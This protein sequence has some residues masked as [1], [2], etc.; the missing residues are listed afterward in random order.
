MARWRRERNRAAGAAARAERGVCQRSPRRGGVRIRRSPRGIS[1][2]CPSKDGGESMICVNSQPEMTCEEAR[3]L[4]VPQ[5]VGDS[6]VTAEERE[7]F[8]G[9]LQACAACVEEYR[10]SSVIVELIGEHRGDRERGQAEGSAFE[11]EAGRRELMPMEEGLADLWRR[12]AREAYAPTARPN[13][14]CLSE[15][16][17]HRMVAVAAVA[18]CLTMAATLWLGLCSHERD[19]QPSYSAASAGRESEELTI[20]LLGV[21]GPRMLRLGE[22]VDSGPDRREVVLGGEH[23]VVMNRNTLAGFAASSRGAFEVELKRGELYVEVTKGHI[24][25]VKTGNALLAITGT[26]FNVR[27]EDDRT[28]LT[29]VEGGIRFSRLR[30]PGTAVH[31]TAGFAS[32]VE[33]ESGPTAPTVV[34]APAVTAWARG[35]RPCDREAAGRTANTVRD[36]MGRRVGAEVEGLDYATWRD[37]HREWF[38]ER[39]PWVFRAQ[40]ALEKECGIEADYMDLLMIS[41][42]I[43]QFHYDAQQAVGQSLV[44][45]EPAAIER[46]AERYHVDGQWLLRAAYPSFASRG[47]TGGGT[48]SELEER[49][50]QALARWRDELTGDGPGTPAD[51]VDRLLFAIRASSYLLTMRTGAYLWTKAQTAEG[52]ALAAREKTRRGSAALLGGRGSGTARQLGRLSDD[53]IALDHAAWIAAQLVSSQIGVACVSYAGQNRLLVEEVS[54]VVTSAN[55]LLLQGTD[56]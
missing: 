2:S 44:V 36:V 34:D 54:V 3:L 19:T 16:K 41:G 45:F 5:A 29:L 37:E 28:E 4:M 18:A 33:G 50:A 49:H 40:L 27:S 6:S 1:R 43:W 14:G 22:A 32:A 7:A 46:L 11:G 17:L 51:R 48:G 12:V 21:S 8:A 42:D 31:V 25:A 55:G 56:D 39:F 15:P 20:E 38:S 53:M 52:P 47:N 13:Q 24:F 35:G 30:E 10:E 23:R 9:H 26:K